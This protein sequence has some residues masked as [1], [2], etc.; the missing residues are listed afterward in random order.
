VERALRECPFVLTV[1]EGCLAGGFGSAVLESAADQG[2]STQHLVR[3]GI[4]DRFVEHG[5][6]AELL[7][8]LGLDLDGL[9]KTCRELAA[10]RG[11][12]GGVEQS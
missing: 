5:D 7:A 9:V 6:R 12:A 2:L 1:E 3:R 10:Q 11:L 4:P 8:D